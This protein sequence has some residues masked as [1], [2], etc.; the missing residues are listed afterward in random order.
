MISVPDDAPPLVFL[1]PSAPA[2][3]VEGILPG[4]ELRPPVR[5]GDLYLA[6]LL[7]YSVFI[8]IDGVF[9]Q[10]EAIPPR[11]VVDVLRDG[12]MVIGA[13]SMGALR[14][15]DCYPAGAIGIGGVYRG[16]R[17]G[18]IGS[19][20]E[21]AVTF[22]PDKPYPSLSLSLVGIRFAVR[23]VARAGLLSSRH[24]T[25]LIEAAQLMPYAE[26]TWPAI[27]RTADV[28]IGEPARAALL[29]E[30]DIKRRDATAALRWVAAKHRNAPDWFRRPRKAR[31]VFAGMEES[32]ERPADGLLGRAPL[33]VGPGFLLWM[34]ISG[35]A[36]R[37]LEESAFEILGRFDLQLPDHWL[38]GLDRL[39]WRTYGA[40]EGDARSVLDRLE[41]RLREA[42]AFD[43]EHFRHAAIAMGVR[44][45]ISSKMDAS[46]SDIETTERGLLKEHGAS[47][48]AA[49][50][51]KLPHATVQCVRDLT[52]WWSRARA[53]RRAAV[54]I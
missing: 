9:A 33:E 1:G 20:D 49:L 14:A 26:R 37:F 51:E 5:R 50:E 6:R 4:A 23:R 32:R 11:E 2:E 30:I 34:L 27:F 31:G 52:L 45:A 54:G 41:T 18:A 43:G 48:L 35:R 38:E 24:A 7:R 10:R 13:S 21:V 25:A 47:G 28:A 46:V 16:F 19:E 22:D 36:N 12:A 3:D 39:D 29:A 53:C 8:V 44:R 42:G 40:G 15:A 17:F